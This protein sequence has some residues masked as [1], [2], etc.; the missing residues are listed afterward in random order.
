M[1]KIDERKA[2]KQAKK[3]GD[4]WLEAFNPGQTPDLLAIE[5]ALAGR[6]HN[7]KPV[8][9]IVVASKNE[10]AEA[11]R[12]LVVESLGPKATEKEITE[13]IKRL[14]PYDNIW[15]YYNMAFFGCAYP[16]VP[17]QSDE[18]GRQSFFEAFKAGLGY[19]LNFGAGAIAIARAQSKLDDQNRIHCATG[20]AVIWGD[21]KQYWW[22]GTQVEKDWIESPKT[23][24][25]KK[26]PSI[27]NAEQRRAFCEIIGWERILAEMKCKLVH[28]D[29]FGELLETNLPG[30]EKEKFVRVICG[31][32][33]TFCIPVPKNS[34]TALEAIASTYGV[35]KEEYKKL[36]V[37]T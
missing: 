1:N 21:E 35:T 25:A 28:Q 7:G 10:A 37:R 18:F 19:Y 4:E 14:R 31:T 33:R 8:R 15:D 23:V 26:M 16:Q 2:L 20:P 22:H 34:K 13:E 3:L 24:D 5:K 12:T 29:E 9:I 27:T 32:G 11:I 30:A 36:E 6:T 17:D